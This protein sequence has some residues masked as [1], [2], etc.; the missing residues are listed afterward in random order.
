MRMEGERA[1][2]S[3]IFEKVFARGDFFEDFGGEIFAIEQEA[4]LRFVE[5]GVVE[6]SEQDLSGGMLEESG[7]AVASGGQRAFA[8]GGGVCGGHATSLLSVARQDSQ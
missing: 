8:I 4:E 6:N 1:F 3:I 2:D 7:E 5:R